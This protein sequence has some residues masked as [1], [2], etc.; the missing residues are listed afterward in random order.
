MSASHRWNQE[1]D[2]LPRRS[3]GAPPSSVA[4]S[5]AASA[6]SHPR[7]NLDQRSQRREP[8]SLLGPVQP[9]GGTE[10]SSL[11]AA[12]G[13]MRD[14]GNVTPPPMRAHRLSGHDIPPLGA[15]AM[16][17]AEEAGPECGLL[18]LPPVS[19]HSGHVGRFL[20]R[21]RLLGESV[22]R[23][24]SGLGASADD[25]SGNAAGDPFHRA[26]RGVEG[27]GDQELRA[28]AQRDREEEG[29]TEC[30]DDSDDPDRVAQ[31]VAPVARA[32]DHPGDTLVLVSS[33]ASTATRGL[34]RLSPSP[35]GVWQPAEADPVYA[36]PR[37]GSFRSGRPVGNSSHRRD[38][39]LHASAQR[40]HE[41]A[42]RTERDHD[43]DDPD[44][45]AQEVAPVA[46]R[47][48]ER[49]GDTSASL[50]P[51]AQAPTAALPRLKSSPV[52]PWQPVPKA[53]PMH[54]RPRSDAFR[55]G[56]ATGNGSPGLNAPGFVDID[57]LIDLPADPGLVTSGDLDDLIGLYI[58]CQEH[59]QQQPLPHL[60]RS[61][62]VSFVTQDTVSKR[63]A[64]QE[65]LP[66][67]EK[68]H[69]ARDA[70]E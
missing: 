16:R 12:P 36:R 49:P 50:L 64:R 29:K 67:L 37:F 52:V 15:G 35:A 60:D 31:E 70:C 63:R 53:Q 41:A 26:P 55:M 48:L 40:D 25:D 47:A 20:G 2:H 44:R 27:E 13:A 32:L 18:P 34:P 45:V 28:S 19:P 46:A 68:P 7:P 9:S 66:S 17:A 3:E 62:L 42:G 54:A 8:A 38:R 33:S 39:E 43:A 21:H 30:D 23:L 11:S 4:A 51:T 10:T 59:P 57:D 6:S 65:P 69:S 5:A 24:A 58:Q 56:T 14:P 22:M 61:E 1:Y